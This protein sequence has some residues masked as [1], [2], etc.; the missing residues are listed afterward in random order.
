LVNLIFVIHNDFFEIHGVNMK[1][2]IGMVLLALGLISATNL[3]A[4][5][6][7][8][9]DEHAQQQE[10]VTTADANASNNSVDFTAEESTEEMD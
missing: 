1:K 10:A 8:G 9:D 3:M 5:D 7:E 4:H 6:W 2:S